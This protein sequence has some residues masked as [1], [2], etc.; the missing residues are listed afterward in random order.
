MI[1]PNDAISLATGGC[2]N[3]CG[4][5]YC[6]KR[7]A[8]TSVPPTYTAS[9][10]NGCPDAS[11]FLASARYTASARNAHCDCSHITFVS[12]VVACGT[13]PNMLVST[14]SMEW[15]RPSRMSMT[16]S[17]FSGGYTW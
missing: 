4:Y 3:C 7:C 8:A 14:E 6:Q 13:E 9:R 15:S 2:S 16:S 5:V 12:S 11:S 10:L 17:C 1:L